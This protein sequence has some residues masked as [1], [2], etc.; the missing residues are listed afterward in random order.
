MYFFASLFADRDPARH[1]DVSDPALVDALLGTPPAVDH[2]LLVTVLLEHNAALSARALATLS[3]QHYT[4]VS[5]QAS[6][7]YAQR[8]RDVAAMS[9]P[10][11]PRV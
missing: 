3:D 4:P 9:R 7:V 8:Q 10:K 6:A 5:E 1:P 11:R 2:H